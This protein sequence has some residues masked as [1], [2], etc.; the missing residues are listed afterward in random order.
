[1]SELVPRILGTGYC[2]PKTIRTNDDPI[3]AWLHANNPPG[4]NLF[5]GYEQRRVLAADEDLMTI[6]LPAAASALAAAKLN[7]ADVDLLL[8]I[9]S[10]SDYSPP[11][12]LSQLHRQLGLSANCWVLPLANDFS[13]F[14]AGLLLADAMIRAG[15]ARTALVVVGTNWTRYVD[16]H[17]PQAISA[18][19]GAAAAVL[20]A[21]KHGWRVV[22]QQ[23]LMATANY[24]SMTMSGQV[25]GF[26]QPVQGY[27]SL[28]TP[29]TFAITPAG[30][31]AFGSFGVQ[32]SVEAVTMLLKR[33]RLKG[34]D[35]SLI[36]HQASSV[37]TEAWK[38][39]IKPAQ[40]IET[41]A[42]FA[43]MT[44]ANIPVNLAWAELNEGV[45]KDHLVLF[46]LGPDMHAHALLLTRD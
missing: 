38:A 4:K 32:K 18:A 2:L 27:S 1:M 19:D 20:G 26:P 7:A 29:A 33:N 34:R 44:A 6:M 28:E 13:N 11:N 3:F 5:A 40:Y 24:G 8:G 22:D 37:L 10:V 45:L 23:V 15:R 36:S 16:Y 25:V 31:A 9:G 43:N 30:A 14:N 39:A 46:A 17:T 12:A 41:L 21:S 42:Q 35:I